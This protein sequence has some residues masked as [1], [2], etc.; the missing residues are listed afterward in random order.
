MRL[1]RAVAERNLSGVAGQ[2]NGCEA[3]SLDGSCGIQE[4]LV[5]ISRITLCF[6]RAAC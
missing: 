3:N 2:G 6:I 5:S 1:V 4:F